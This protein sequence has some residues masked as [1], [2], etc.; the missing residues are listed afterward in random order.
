MHP[1]MDVRESVPSED[2][3]FARQRMLATMSQIDRREWWLWSTAISVTLL[4]AMGIASFA[5]PALLSGFDSFDVFFLDHVVR[6]L[7]GLILLFNIYIVYEQIQINR[8]RKEFAD[9][10]YNMAVLDPV[11]NMFNRRYIVHRL[12]EEIA[13]CERHGGP[14]TVITL[15]LD[16]FKRVNDEHGHAVGDQ[17]LRLFADQLKRATRGSDLAA[18]YGGDEFLVML[19]DC[20]IEQIQ[21]VLH[22]LNGLHVETAQFR[23]DI[24]YSAGWADYVPGE[25]LTDLLQRADEMLYAN[26]RNLKGPPVD[27]I[28]TQ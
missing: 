18:R 22:R 12:E 5:L 26:K 11:T 23:I 20:N 19:P 15:D 8:I 4:L 16:C 6:G 2:S 9:N 1:L 13:R 27:S 21:H 10:L 3:A 14:L 7:L 17:V 25:S 24:Q 28:V